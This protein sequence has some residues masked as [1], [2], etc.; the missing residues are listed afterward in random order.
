V[1]VYDGFNEARANNA[2]PWIYR[3]DYGHYGWYEIVNMLARY[4]GSASFAL[5]YTLHYIAIRMRQVLLSDRYVPLTQPRED[6]LRFGRNHRSVVSFQHNLEAILALASQRGDRLLLMTFATYVP[7]NYSR[8]AFAHRQLDYGL[9]LLAIEEWGRP[10]HVLQTVALENE[11][12]RREAAQHK[13]VLF[14]DQASLMAGSARYFTDPCHLTV[15]GASKF[16]DNLLS[17]VVPILGTR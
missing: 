8:Q 4:H 9:H 1:V 17:V 5:P 13:E 10:D 14:V 6:W 12:I 7:D 15:V 16:V 2:P 3:E 11:V